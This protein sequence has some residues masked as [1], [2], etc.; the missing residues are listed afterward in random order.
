MQCREIYGS[1][2]EFQMLVKYA[3]IGYE[4]FLQHWIWV[5]FLAKS[6]EFLTVL[7]TFSLRR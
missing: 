5:V 4:K 1:S 6:L 2:Y 7:M 3:N